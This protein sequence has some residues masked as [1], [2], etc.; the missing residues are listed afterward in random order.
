[1]MIYQLPFHK[2]DYFQ[3]VIESYVD[4]AEEL[5]DECQEFRF[6]RLSDDEKRFM[7][8]EV[9]GVIENMSEIDALIAGNAKKWTF[10]RLARVD[11]AIMRLAVFELLKANDVPVRVSI[12]EA[13]ELCKQFGD[14][15]SYAYVNGVLGKIAF[16][17]RGEDRAAKGETR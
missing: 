5:N 11:L 14:E 6:A 17:T 3:E 7:L 1:M 13:V 8:Y 10:D 2:P 9:N 12:N 15:G 4:V 16:I